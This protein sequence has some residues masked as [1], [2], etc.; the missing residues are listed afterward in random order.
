[1]C[2][3]LIV[4]HRTMTAIHVCHI[5]HS[6]HSGTRWKPWSSVRA[7]NCAT[8]SASMGCGPSAISIGAGACRCG[9]RVGGAGAGCAGAGSGGSWDG[10]DDT[11]SPRHGNGAKGKWSQTAGFPC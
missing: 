8:P 1:M 4:D 11:G 6:V 7:T 10:G 5:W 3:Y 9:A 2:C